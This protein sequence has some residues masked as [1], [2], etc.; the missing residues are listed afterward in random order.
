MK[1]RNCT[2]LTAKNSPQLSSSTRLIS[3]QTFNK[4]LRTTMLES[5]TSLSLLPLTK[6]RV[7]SHPSQIASPQY[8]TDS[9]HSQVHKHN[10]RRATTPKTRPRR[11]KALSLHHLIPFNQKGTNRGM[12]R[13]TENLSRLGSGPRAS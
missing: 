1:T 10:P 3:Q 6:R 4:S 8:L 13:R 7:S 11:V 2:D 5:F 12:P 9:R